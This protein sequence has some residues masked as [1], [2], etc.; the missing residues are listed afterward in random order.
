[1]FSPPYNRMVT[2]REVRHPRKTSTFILTRSELSD[3]I[4]RQ[5]CN[6]KLEK[7]QQIYRT[8]R[9]FKLFSLNN[10]SGVLV[11]CTFVVY[12]LCT[13]EFKYNYR[14]QIL[15]NMYLESREVI[16]AKG[17][18]HISRVMQH[19]KLVRHDHNWCLVLISNI[20][21][22]F[23]LSLVLYFRIS[24]FLCFCTLICPYTDLFPFL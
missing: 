1:M 15:H 18:F 7:D 13:Y 16:M 8:V 9:K 21:F 3:P 19:D 22:H 2:P 5:K 6:R 4:I 24:L 23:Q 10:Y 12:F 14:G 17:Y 20:I 11:I